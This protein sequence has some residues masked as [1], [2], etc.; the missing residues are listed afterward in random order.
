MLELALGGLSVLGGLLG[1]RSAK[2]GAKAQAQAAEQAYQRS[3]AVNQPYMDTGRLG[4]ENLNAVSGGD[5]SRFYQSP[6]YQFRMSQGVQALD[7]S[8]AAR[9]LVKSGGQYKGVLRYGQGLA[10]GEFQNWYARNLGLANLGQQ[11]A[12]QVAQSAYGTGQQVGNAQASGY[13]NQ[14][15]AWTNAMQQ[16]VGLYGLY[17]GGYFGAPTPRS[18]QPPPP[19]STPRWPT[20]QPGYPG[21]VGFPYGG[22]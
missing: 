5:M 4:L 14:G 17:Q 21:T 10:S 6:D 1:S 9:G 22:G 3:L 16:G 15:N 2:K 7:R 13:I 8:A 18:V 19:L 11:S 12:G 20:A